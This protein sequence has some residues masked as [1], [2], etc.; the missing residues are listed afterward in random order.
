MRPVCTPGPAGH[1]SVCGDEAVAVRV[2]AVD[3][4]TDTARVEGPLEA[5]TVALDLVEDVTVGDRL[6]VHMGFAIA[7]VEDGD[8][9]GASVARHSAETS[10]AGEPSHG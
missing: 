6:M 1:C 10:E 9:A 7:R 5:D 8:V 2:L 3:R 4:T